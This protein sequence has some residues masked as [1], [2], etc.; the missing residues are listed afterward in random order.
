MNGEQ[1]P[2]EEVDTDT[3]SDAL[4]PIRVMRR[5]PNR[6][7]VGLAQLPQQR[8]SASGY[9]CW[10]LPDRPAV[11]VLAHLTL[12]DAELHLLVF[13][14]L[15]YSAATHATA[16]EGSGCG[17]GT[18]A[19]GLGADQYRASGHGHLCRALRRGASD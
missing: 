11:A 9:P 12:R 3:L 7:T 2:S 10:Q 16:P 19:G 17:D 4:E 18:A 13:V 1:G 6:R 15:R 8:S 14:R 5:L